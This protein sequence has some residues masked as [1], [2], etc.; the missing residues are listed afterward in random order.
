MTSKKEYIA[1]NHFHKI[2]ER[3]GIQPACFAYVYLVTKDKEQAHKW[4]DTAP[5]EALELMDSNAIVDTM[6]RAILY[7]KRT[8]IDKEL[9]TYEIQSYEKPFEDDE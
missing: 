2:R 3:K 5:L 9:D 1:R 4:A 7:S 6:N 8:Q